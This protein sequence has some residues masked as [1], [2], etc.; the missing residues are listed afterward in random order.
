MRGKG[1]EVAYPEFCGKAV[2]EKMIGHN[3]FYHPP[4]LPF[5]EGTSF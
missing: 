3:L 5:P 2:A 1:R 4:S